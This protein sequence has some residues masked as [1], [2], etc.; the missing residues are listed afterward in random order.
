MNIDIVGYPLF[1]FNRCAE[2]LK[3]NIND[4]PFRV[5]KRYYFIMNEYH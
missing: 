1:A 3:L 2:P 4:L 5:N